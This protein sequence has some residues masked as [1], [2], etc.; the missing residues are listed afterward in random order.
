[1]PDFTE[2]R[3]CLGCLSLVSIVAGFGAGMY[4][5]FKQSKGI[6]TSSEM[7]YV[8]AITTGVLSLMYGADLAN[9]PAA[10][11]EERRITGM[12][13]EMAEQAKGCSI[14]SKGIVG[15]AMTG[16]A[17]GIGYWIGKSLN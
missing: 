4:C 10:V 13:R 9:D 1:M 15:T 14:I 11:E 8:P 12:P 7:L 2:K 16:V 3:G 17:T 5:G 6:P